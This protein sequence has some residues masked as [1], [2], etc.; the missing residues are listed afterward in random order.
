VHHAAPPE[1]YPDAQ[2]VLG[3]AAVPIAPNTIIFAEHISP[4][5][6]ETIRVMNK[7]S[8]NLHAELLL[9]A[10]GHEKKGSG[11]TDAGIW[12]E[13]DFLKSAGIADGDVVFSDGSGLSIDELVTPRAM[14]QLLRYDS[15]Q[16]WGADYISTFPIAGVDGTLEN[17]LKDT[18]AAGK[19]LAKTGRLEHVSAMSGFATTQEGE[20]LVFTIFGNN[21]TS[22]GRD[23]TAAI[24]AIAVDMIKTLGVPAA[25]SQHKRKK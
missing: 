22:R 10:V 20:R 6:V 4:P 25:H 11:V 7:V 5:L 9:R 19:I 14:V 17:R 24:D 21:S 16:P 1:I 2:V 13:Q 8:Q 3:P 15:I 12:A 23:A 18:V